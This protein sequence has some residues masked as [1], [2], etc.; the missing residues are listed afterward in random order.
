MADRALRLLHVFPSF[1]LG[2]QQRRLAALVA[3]L[4]QGFR[5]R[6][7]ALDGDIGAFSLIAAHADITEAAPLEFR[8]S[9]GVDIGNLL[10]LRK[11]ISGADADVLCT[12]NWGSIE[13]VM[14]NAVGARLP[15]VHHEDGFGP[16]EAGGRQIGRRVQ[17]RRFALRNAFVTVPSKVLEQ[18]AVEDWRLDPARVTRI[19]VGVDLAKF[20]K[21]RA[22]PEA[23]PVIVGAIGGLR[24]EKNLAR[25]IRA[26][27]QA[28]EG[29]AARLEIV[30]DGP[31]RARL[32]ALA[33][34]SRAAASIRFAGSTDRPEDAHA[35]FDIFALS[36]DTEQTPTSLIEAM[37]SGLPAVAP[38]VGD[39]PS[40]VSKANRPFISEP[41]DDAAFAKALRAM[42]ADRALRVAVG[43]ANAACAENYDARTMI[44]AFRAL[45][46]R[47]A[48]WR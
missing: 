10:R 19:P 9:R 28:S 45:Y 13:A 35:R 32:E 44:D 42:I 38:G 34:E 12:Y 7:Y 26:F 3:G 30:G 48:G 15:V 5:H 27:E 16:E 14:A 23:G 2:G 17:T 21:P 43:A 20:R 36:S 22:R 18:I 39:I 47:A 6:I 1:A 46:E 41:G 4:G 40:M 33:Q 31:E 24:P 11:A 37:A 8:K 25:L 29:L